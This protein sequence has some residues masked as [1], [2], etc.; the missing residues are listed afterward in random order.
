V[1]RTIGSWLALAVL[2]LGG[3]AGAQELK[4]LAVVSLGG[5]EKIQKAAALIGKAAE[6]PQLPAMLD[7]MVTMVTQGKG[8]N[9][10]DK[11]R[12]WGAVVASDG[13]QMVVYGFVPTADLKGLLGSLQMVLGPTEEKDGAFSIEVKDTPM[14][15]KQKG[16]WAY[17]ARNLE[18]LA[19]VADDPAKLLGDLPKQYDLAV[20]LSLA[21]VPENYRMLLPILLQ[22]GAQI[23]KLEG[24]SDAEFAKRKQATDESIQATVAMI[25][26]LNE[27][28]VGL[29]FDEAAT[30]AY[31]DV[32]TTAKPGSKTA[33]AMKKSY[34]GAT[35]V[36][37]ALT[38]ADAALSL[39]MASKSVPSEQ[40][41]KQFQAMLA[42]ARSAA[43]RKFQ[44]E[45]LSGDELALAKQSLDDVLGVIEKT[46]MSGQ[47]DGAAT[48]AFDKGR[49]TVVGGM[50]LVDGQKIAAAGKRIID[51]VGKDEP[52][53]TEAVK[54]NVDKVGGVSLHK[55]A[56]PTAEIDANDKALKSLVG[57]TFEFA[58]GTS[59]DA[60]YVALGRDAYAALKDAVTKVTSAT[61][62]SASPATVTVTLSPIMRAAADIGPEPDRA[63]VNAISAELAKAKGKDHLQITSMPVPDGGKVRIEIEEGLL[64]LLGNITQLAG[65]Q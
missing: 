46:V 20:R 32:A 51:R 44:E 42:S 57:D 64:R 31:L 8:L 53:V 14:F 19:A 29:A 27:I 2:A 3:Y 12:P 52:R 59:D 24:E 26:D 16:Q 49:L 40:D 17:I 28:T 41:A 6:N 58:A 13:Q 61:A 65:A 23:E 54:L 55:A 36:F 22:Q 38:Q 15:L 7:G 47:I 35:S 21:N 34:S 18:T 9:A 62:K 56:V 39:A 25:N 63:K 10:V 4:P 33:E 37:S 11:A 30:K 1:R 50:K 45:G 48:V 5:Y 43:A 60:I